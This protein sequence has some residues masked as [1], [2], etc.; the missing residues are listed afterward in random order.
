MSK[1]RDPVKNTTEVYDPFT[2]RS[3]RQSFDNKV[4]ENPWELPEISKET[5]VKASKDE[6]RGHDG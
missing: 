5:P 6:T 2:A 1:E 4:F 3:R